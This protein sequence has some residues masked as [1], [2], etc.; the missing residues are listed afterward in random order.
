MFQLK[1]VF[2]RYV[3]EHESQVKE[4]RLTLH[5]LRKDPMAIFALGIIGLFVFIALFA[6]WIAPHPEQGLGEPN[7][8]EKLQGIS[9]NHPFGTD[10]F[11]RDVLSRIILGTR[12]SLFVGTLVVLI[13][14]MI[15][16]PLGAAAG[17]YGGKFD[18]V[19]MRITDMFLAFP[20][21]LL[22]I[23]IISTI[24][25]GLFNAMFAITITWWPWYTR[26]VRGQAISI[27]EREFVTASRSMG[28]KNRSIVFSDI[29]P[30]ALPSV[31][32]QATM[33]LGSS[34]LVMASLGFL[35]LGQLPPAP[36]WGSMIF[37][38]RNYV[39]V[40]PEYVFFPGLAIFLSVLAFNLL[41][42]SLRVIM[43]PRLRRVG[44]T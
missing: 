27:R 37:R 23:V 39:F 6:P 7:L 31:I 16:T 13:A 22:A 21:L 29:I 2:R 15:G 8:A 10:Y 9:W 25:P 34:I 44:V 38:A 28:V 19:V 32:I 14:V 40:R 5:L 36:G 1:R 18:E 33:D 42:D 12:S 20:N 24:G 3:D 35:G 43:D 41:G 26:L 30:N 11:G 4:W 17:Y